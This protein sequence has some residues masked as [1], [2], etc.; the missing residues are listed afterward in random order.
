MLH[1]NL[2]AA[3]FKDFGTFEMDRFKHSHSAI[4]LLDH[5]AIQSLGQKGGKRFLLR[6]GGKKTE[7]VQRSHPV[8]KLPSPNDVSG[9]V[10]HC[11]LP[12]PPQISSSA[13]SSSEEVPLSRGGAVAL[14]HFVAGLLFFDQH[15]LSCGG[16]R[17]VRAV[18][19]GRLRVW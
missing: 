14:A 8:L 3:E 13:S 17:W 7:V 2:G 16:V 4:Q 5:S 15:G 9:P 19:E 12:L 18:G 11:A 10:Q 1:P 6:T